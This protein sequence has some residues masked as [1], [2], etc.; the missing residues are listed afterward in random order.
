[1]LNSIIQPERKQYDIINNKYIDYFYHPVCEIKCLGLSIHVENKFRKTPGTHLHVI[2]KLFSIFN[3][4]YESQIAMV[5]THL[6][7]CIIYDFYNKHST[8]T[9]PTSYTFGNLTIEHKQFN[10]TTVQ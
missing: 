1:M 2:V 3:G 4:I 8:L 7:P 6:L 5:K 9:L 10:F